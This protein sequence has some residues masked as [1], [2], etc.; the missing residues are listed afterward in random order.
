[1][2][3]FSRERRLKGT[4]DEKRVKDFGSR[5]YVQMIASLR[6]LTQTRSLFNELTQ[7]NRTIY[8][9]TKKFNLN[10]SRSHLSDAAT[11]KRRLKHANPDY[12]LS[13]KSF[14]KIIFTFQLYVY[15]PLTQ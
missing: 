7:R 8:S 13:L 5:F 4:V 3:L 11:L 12:A 9:S 1:M 2:L 6:K 14:E 10:S 15:A